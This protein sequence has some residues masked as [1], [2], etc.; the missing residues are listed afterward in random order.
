[1]YA[2]CS[3]VVTDGISLEQAEKCLETIKDRRVRLAGKEILPAFYEFSKEHR[4][5]GLSAFK[6]FSTPYPIGRSDGATLSIP[7]VPTF[8][9]L[10]GKT[11]VPVFLIGWARM[12]LDDYQKRLLSTIIYDAILT[13]QDFMGSD[14][15]IICTPRHRRTRTRHILTW[16]SHDYADL[17]EEELQEQ[18]ARYRQALEDLIRALRAK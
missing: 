1:V 15:L 5:A 12:S 17:S 9:M 3:A 7:V 14:A 8:T 2:V 4:L 6:G 10:N 16:R 13:Q 18:F 11:L